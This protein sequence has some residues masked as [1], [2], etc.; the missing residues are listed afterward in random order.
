MAPPSGATRGA[1]AGGVPRDDYSWETA[2]LMAKFRKHLDFARQAMGDF[3]SDEALARLAMEKAYAE[4]GTTT[5][6]PPPP[7]APA[8]PP[9]PKEPTFDLAQAHIH[10]PAATV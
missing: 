6:L 7:A 8:P 4:V 10:V 5:A 1:E 9:P 2:H 3:L